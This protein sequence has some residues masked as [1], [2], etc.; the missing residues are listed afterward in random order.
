MIICKQCE[1]KNTD[2][3][4][5]CARCGAQLG[6]NRSPHEPPG[7]CIIDKYPELKF[8]PTIGTNWRQP[9][10]ILIAVVVGGGLC[11]ILIGLIVIL[12]FGIIY[13]G[14]YGLKKTNVTYPVFGKL[15][16]PQSVNYSLHDVA[17]YIED[18]KTYYFKRYCIIVK[19]SKFGL[20]DYNLKKYIIEPKYEYL[21]WKQKNK[22]IYAQNGNG[23]YVM[24]DVPSGMIL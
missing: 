2:T 3:A 22:L 9:W 10:D 14:K 16:L 18:S 5:F 1:H 20:L 4:Q 7:T 19:N 6:V 11:L 12:V 21:K 17:D 15:K 24:I 8:Q 13:I 23:E